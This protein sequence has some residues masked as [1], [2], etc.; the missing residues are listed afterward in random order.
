MRATG[1]IGA[2]WLR[3]GRGKGN[4]RFRQDKNLWL[5]QF[6]LPTGKKKVKYGQTQ[7]E[8]RAWL[9]EQRR[10]ARQGL[11]V[12]NDQVTFGEFLLRWYDEVARHR[13]RPATLASHASVMRRHILPTLSISV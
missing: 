4:I 10:L 7:K 2:T 13:L 1:K 12:A 6:T 3:D 8:V 11:V 5:A 9:E